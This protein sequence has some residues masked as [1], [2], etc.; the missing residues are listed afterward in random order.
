MKWVNTLNVREI[1]NLTFLW[2]G[3]DNWNRHETF[4]KVG[5]TENCSRKYIQYPWLLFLFSF[6]KTFRQIR[7]HYSTQINTNKDFYNVLCMLFDKVPY[8]SS[9]HP[10][11]SY[12]ANKFKSKG[13]GSSFQWSQEGEELCFLVFDQK[14]NTEGFSVWLWFFYLLLCCCLLLKQ[15]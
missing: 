10:K 9:L 7:K 6:W 1:W 12:R 15:V 2:F 14:R 5:N 3:T 8:M 4:R 11:A 13:L